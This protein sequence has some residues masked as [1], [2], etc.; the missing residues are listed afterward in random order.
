VR[1]SAPGGVRIL[2]PQDLAHEPDRRLVLEAVDADVV[3]DGEQQR[4]EAALQEELEEGVL[5]QPADVRE[6]AV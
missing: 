6:H 4:E 5:R 2:L 1:R 3:D